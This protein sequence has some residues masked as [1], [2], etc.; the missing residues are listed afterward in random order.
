VTGVRCALKCRKLK[1]RF[2]GSFDIIEK[3]EQ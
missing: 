3:V 2:V 1:P